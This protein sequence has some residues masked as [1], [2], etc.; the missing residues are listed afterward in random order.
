MGIIDRK[1]FGRGILLG[2]ATD[3]SVKAIIWLVGGGVGVSVL[4]GVVWYFTEIAEAHPWLRLALGTVFVLILVVLWLLAFLAVERST[5]AQSVPAPRDPVFTV[6]DYRGNGGIYVRV[7]LSMAAGTGVMRFRLET[8]GQQPLPQDDVFKADDGRVHIVSSNG[9]TWPTN[10]GPSWLTTPST[11]ENMARER[12]VSGWL[13]FS[14]PRAYGPAGG[15]QLAGHNPRVV[16]LLSDGRTLEAAV[17][18][19]DT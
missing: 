14:P 5:R 13:S 10:L 15:Y 12:V 17:P 16:A 18:M 11:P 1:G 9:R 3:L 19:D 4:G 7:S 2:L 6:D 8:D